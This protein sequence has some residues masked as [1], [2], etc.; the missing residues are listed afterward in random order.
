VKLTLRAYQPRAEL[1]NGQY[2]FPGIEPA[3]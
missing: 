2:R 1:L 3:D